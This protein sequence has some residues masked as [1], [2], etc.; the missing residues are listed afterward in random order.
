MENTELKD[1]LLK[2]VESRIK[3]AVAESTEATKVN[4]LKE[5]KELSPDFT[6]EKAAQ[7]IKESSEGIEDI[8][9]SVNKE[10]NDRLDQMEVNAKKATKGFAPVSIDEAIEKALNENLDALKVMKSGSKSEAKNSG[11]DFEIKAAGTITSSN[12]S[13]GNVPVEDRVD[14]LNTV[15]S[16]NVKFLDTL[17]RRSTDSNIVSWTY[18]ANKDG[19]AGQTAEG[20]AK[21]QIDF[22]IVVASQA[23]KK[24]TA[25]IKVS[26]EMLDDV[27]WMRSEING[28]L[29]RE[30]MKAVESQAW[31]GD[32]TGQNLNGI[33]NT[34]TAFAAG[35]FANAIDN[36]NDVDVL[37]VAINQIKIAEQDFNRGIIFMNPSDVTAL[38]MIKVSSTDKRYVERLAMVAGNLSLDGT[39]IVESTLVTAGDYLV[40]DMSKAFLVQK[41]GLRI[42]IGLDA[43][44]FTKNLRTVLA[45]WRG[46]TFVKNN[47]RTAFVT[48]TFATDA[49]ALETT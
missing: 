1:Q 35:T 20:A 15:P 7:L 34:A 47:D 30:L 26:T 3:E 33:V 48:G 38:K 21:N 16:R 37:T 13:G 10:I 2:S 29:T 41:Q 45:E 28:E 44:D 6:E 23:V 32:N 43:D 27:S 22:D 5:V 9:K 4:L 40:G 25:Y 49:A 24:T 18:Q 42:D 12:I 11:F 46:L 17:E 39:P 19:S 31:D 14:G 36:A 8:I